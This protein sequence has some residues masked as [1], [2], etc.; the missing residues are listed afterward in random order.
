MT[1]T[2][3]ARPG[4]MYGWLSRVGLARI[5]GWTCTASGDRRS[6]CAKYRVAAEAA[7][8][9]RRASVPSTTTWTG[10]DR[11]RARRLAVSG[12]NNTTAATS[13]RSIAASAASGSR[14]R[15][16]P[17][18]VPSARSSSTRA[19]VSAESS[20]STIAVGTRS[21]SKLTANP[22]IRSWMSGAMINSRINRGSAE[23][24]ASSLR[25]TAT[26]R[27]AFTGGVTRSSA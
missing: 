20:W 17:R 6:A 22:K 23:I 15:R 4:T 25:I 19:R 11:P 7:T 12:G 27:T 18:N 13:P 3:A 10:A 2:M 1:S 24:W 5:L 9:D 14:V 26:R 8:P 21:T 16:T